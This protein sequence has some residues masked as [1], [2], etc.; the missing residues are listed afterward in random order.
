MDQLWKALKHEVA[1]N[2]QADSI[3]GLCRPC[4][5]VDVA[6]DACPGTPESRYGFPNFWLRH[7]L[8]DFRLPT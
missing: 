3:D 5:A 6:P 7:V 1:A 8:H 2:R 4:G